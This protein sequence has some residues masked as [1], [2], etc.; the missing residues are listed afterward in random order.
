MMKWKPTHIFGQHH[1]TFLMRL[2]DD[3][4]VEGGSFGDK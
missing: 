4:Q 2:E 1:E 3:E